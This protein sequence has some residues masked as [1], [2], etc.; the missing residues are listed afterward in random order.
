MTGTA[1]PAGWASHCSQQSG[2]EPSVAAEGGMA[3]C[4]PGDKRDCVVLTQSAMDRCLLIVSKA[5]CSPEARKKVLIA[6][7]SLI[8]ANLPFN[9]DK[10]RALGLR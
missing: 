3:R 4:H 6:G 2:E 8:L 10:P 9:K 1:R 5:A 7:M